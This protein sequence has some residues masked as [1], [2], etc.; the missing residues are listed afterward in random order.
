MKTNPFGRAILKIRIILFGL[1]VVGMTGVGF[2]LGEA[3]TVR[4]GQT[5]TPQ[6]P[7]GS[8]ADVMAAAHF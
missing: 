8:L 7:N 4:L 5:T 1:A 3:L 6:S 2:S